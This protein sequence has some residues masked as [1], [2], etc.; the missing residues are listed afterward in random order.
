MKAAVLFLLVFGCT[1]IHIIKKIDEPV[2]LKDAYFSANS[3][4]LEIFNMI[5]PEKHHGR[6]LRALVDLEQIKR[7]LAFSLVNIGVNVSSAS[8]NTLT[9]DLNRF[10]VWG[11]PGWFTCKID[12]SITARAFINGTS[13]APRNFNKSERVY[14]CSF[15][16]NDERFKDKIRQIM[17]ENVS[18]I[19]KYVQS[20]QSRGS[21]K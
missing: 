19:I 20:E 13:I 1:H 10:Y 21:N 2:D 18:D 4:R 3:V 15:T 5:S 16:G 8:S 6:D 17:G 7:Q 12:I 14:F 9:F 11:G